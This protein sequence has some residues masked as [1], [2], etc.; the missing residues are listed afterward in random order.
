MDFGWILLNTAI[1]LWVVGFFYQ[2]ITQE[3][4]WDE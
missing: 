2:I 1:I 4:Y 3:G